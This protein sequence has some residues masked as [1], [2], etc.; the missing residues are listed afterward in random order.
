MGM[1]KSPV[2]TDALDGRDSFEEPTDMKSIDVKTRVALT[3]EGVE[4]FRKSTQPARPFISADGFEERGLTLSNYDPRSLQKLFLRG[5]VAHIELKIAKLERD[6][7]PILDITK[8][9]GYSVLYKQFDSALR[10]QLLECSSVKKWNRHNPRS[11]IDHK[12]PLFSSELLKAVRANSPVL[13][14]T[15]Q[16]ILEPL[17]HVVRGKKDLPEHER[18]VQGWVL[19]KLLDSTTPLTSFLLVLHQDQKQHPAVYSGVHRLLASYLD[20]SV[21]P[22]YLALVTIELLQSLSERNDRGCSED[23]SERYVV[24]RV[25]KRDTMRGDRA[26]LHVSI[27]S[28]GRHYNEIRGAINEKTATQVRR[29]SLRDFYLHEQQSEHDEQTLGLYYLS[30]MHERCRELQVVFNSFMHRRSDENGA[31]VNLVLSL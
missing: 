28:D 21:L 24:F 18:Q 23:D 7:R 2:K 13:E 15:K 30:F 22:E 16:R 6:R 10:D 17:L 31:L 9:V 4:Y 5:F 8:L 20:R 25:R 19:E 14:E 3:D 29:K 26:K 27:C 1:D 11:V 12:T